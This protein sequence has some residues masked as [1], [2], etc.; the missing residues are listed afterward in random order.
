[1][2]MSRSLAEELGGFGEEY[3]IGD[4]ED[5]DLCLK[6]KARGLSC[7]VDMSVQLYHL[8]RQSQGSPNDGWRMNLTLYNAWV[9]QRRWLKAGAPYNVPSVESK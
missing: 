7:A 5:S 2:V 8:E 3:I 1:M 6:A 9:H 4:F